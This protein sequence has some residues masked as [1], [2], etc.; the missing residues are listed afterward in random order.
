VS[1]RSLVSRS[2]KVVS[3]A[4]WQKIK[5][6]EYSSESWAEPEFHLVREFVDPN[7]HA[8]DAGVH[9]GMYTRRFSELAKGV[10]AFEANPDSAAFARRSLG[11]LARIEAVA[12][13]SEA[14]TARLRV[15]LRPEGAMPWAGTISADHALYDLEYRTVEV[16]TRRLDDYDLPPIGFIKI[17]VEGHEE[18]VL[19]GAWALIARDRPCLMIE[20]EERH[21]AGAV[22]RIAAE[23]KDRSYQ[24]LFHD[25][26]QY[27]D[28]AVFSV[29]RHQSIGSPPYIN[30]FFFV[31]RE[32][33][34]APSAVQRE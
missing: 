10:I 31:P 6:H 30:N 22:R 1:L 20:I 11:H 2:L 17:D 33:R 3:P 34:K 25:G 29:E 9:L 27:Q 32:K 5:Y 8:I 23:F 14:G 7:R 21:N 12:L 4:L 28:I 16:P 26:T 13:S 24:V 15:P 19:N 18:A